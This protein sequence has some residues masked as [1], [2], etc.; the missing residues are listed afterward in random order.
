MNKLLVFLQPEK[1]VSPTPTQKQ[2]TTLTR[3]ER[4][5]LEDDTEIKEGEEDGEELSP[6]EQ[7]IKQSE[8]IRYVISSLGS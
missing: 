1:S 4:D 3:T 7:H 8:V 6:L 2:S 5:D